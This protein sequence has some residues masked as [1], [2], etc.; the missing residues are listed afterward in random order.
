MMAN[1]VQKSSTGAP[2][3]IRAAT[4]AP[5]GCL[6][7]L[8]LAV[9]TTFAITQPVYDRLTE[10]PA[11]LADSGLELPGVV[12]LV[13]L[14]SV[15]VPAIVAGVVIAAGRMLPRLRDSIYAI[16]VFGLLVV[17]SLPFAKRIS[18]LPGWQ[19]LFVALGLAAA[20]TWSYFRFRRCRS[21]VTAAAPAI[22]IFPIVFLFYSPVHSLFVEPL[23]VRTSRENPAPVVVLV[24][25][26]FRGTTLEN[27]QREIDARRFPH[28]AELARG[29]TW[30]RNATSVSPDTWTAVPA[31]LTGKYPAQSQAPLPGD[32]PQNLFSVLDTAGGYSEAVFE[33]VSRL[34]RSQSE[35]SQ[36]A[37]GNP[38]VL[39]V[40][41]ILPTLGRVSLF[42][43][44]P[45][46]L[47]QYLP[48]IPRLWFGL[49]DSSNVDRSLRR[50]VFRYNW[51][52]N[53][54]E[55][56]DHFLDCL[57]GSSQPALYFQ[58]ILL[59]HVPWCYL[60]SGR[61]YLKESR[62][63]ELLN[64]DTHGDLADFWG[65]DELI[66]IHSQQRHLL[67]LQFVDR[68]VGRLLDRLHET[69]LFENCLLIVTADHGICFQ[70][71]EPRRAP[72]PG[73]LG[74]ILSIPLFIKFPGQKSGAVSDRNVESIDILPTISDVLGIRMRM[75]IDGQSLLDANSP[76]R[77]EKRY[78]ANSQ[79]N[80]VRP[81]D[82]TTSR[83][84]A[85]LRSRFGP[86]S[87]SDSLYR[88]APRPELLGKAVGQLSVSN[89][90]PVEIELLR[91]GTFYSSD[92]EAVVPCYFEGRV[93]SVADSGQPVSIAV[94]VNGT[95]RAV[96]RTYQIDGIRD[97]WAAM[98]PET[99]FHEG[100]NDV[101]YFT[102]E[103]DG[104]NLRLSPCIAKPAP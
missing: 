53:R 36:P 15:I 98:V 93:L 19:I 45:D 34:A 67:Q 48:A 89:R 68:L 24:F 96:T 39:L 22:A 21:L 66:V 41:A 8:H 87:D 64:F 69:G 103:S 25:D 78:F 10:R 90:Q 62:Q 55:Q 81:S 79:M 86:A 42:H 35:A 43:L 46:D 65:T 102:V 57:D 77:N 76:E 91:S 101:Q 32:L 72:D 2:S 83:G 28:F 31:L 6:A 61:N 74:D 26:E 97:R 94:A 9:V 73:N 18:F 5:T 33:P 11:F 29:S 84:P 13:V 4:T 3:A 38:S 95:I 23:A 71:G 17:I 75:P 59:P 60:P 14:L 85:E 104:P 50:G 20:G 54:R 49:G 88:I 99:A 40:A 82:L 47:H 30:F 58:H 92:P 63:F 51:G 37:A 44:L 27:E 56:F 100:E 52:E 1:S 7:F 16:A 12:L 70:T 80:S